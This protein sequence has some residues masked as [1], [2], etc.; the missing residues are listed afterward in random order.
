MGK[1]RDFED[2]IVNGVNRKTADVIQAY[3]IGFSGG[4]ATTDGDVL[5]TDANGGVNHLAELKN[6]SS[7]YCYV[8]TEQL[9]GLVS[10]ENACT[11]V[12][13]VVKFSR[14]EPLV[15]RY[16]DEITVDAEEAET[17][18]EA[19]IVQKFAYRAPSCFDASVT[20]S[21]KLSLKKP[22]TDDWPSAS[23]GSSDTD[24]IISGLGIP[25]ED[26]ISVDR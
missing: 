12:Y 22:D 4:H 10:R 13:L 18:N 23:A 17:Y 21:G 3:P 2:R 9:E 26:S 7:D 8:E 20:D 19:S 15:M 5:V 16:F 1:G 6:I 14:R 24:A 25:T 11:Y